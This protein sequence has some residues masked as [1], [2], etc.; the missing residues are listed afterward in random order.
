MRLAQVGLGSGVGRLV[1]IL[2]F[3]SGEVR[4]LIYSIAKTPD[5]HRYL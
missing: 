1:L 5:K 4:V 2:Q 3:I